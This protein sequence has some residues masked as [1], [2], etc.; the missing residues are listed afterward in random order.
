MLDNL[1][2]S[3]FLLDSEEQATE[4]L[5]GQDAKLNCQYNYNRVAR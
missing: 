3:K 5:D 4:L 2:N 1:P